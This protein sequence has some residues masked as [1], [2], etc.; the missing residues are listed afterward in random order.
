MNFTRLILCFAAVL[1]TTSILC[2]ETVHIVVGKNAP[3]LENFAAEEL[4]GQLPQV[5]EDVTAAVVGKIPDGATHVVLI[6]SPTTSDHVKAAARQKWPKLSDQ[7]IVVK[8]LSGDRQT[9]LVGGGSPVATLWA[10]Y[11]LGHRL[12]IRYLLRGDIFPIEKRPL[13][14]TGH[15]LVTEP[16]LRSRTWRT[17]NDF[18]IGPES[19]GLADH[20]KALKQL[21][22]LKY[23]RLMLQ[24]YPWQPFVSYEFDGVKKKTATLW[25]G[26]KF[27]VDGDTVGKKVFRGAK[28]FENPDLAGL[29]TSEELT[30]AGVGHVRGLIDAAHELGMTVGISISP[31][32]FPREFQQALPGSRVAHGLK[33]L[34]IIPAADQGPTDETL[35]KIVATKI[36]AYLETYP[37]LDT[38][39]LTMPEFPE[40]D[41][42]ADQAWKLLRPRLGDS[43]IQLAD[44]VKQA[45]KRGL[46][47]SGQRG[48]Q[49]LKGNLVGLA[50][51]Q[52]LF[53]DKDLLKR[54]GGSDTELF[55]TSVDPALYPVLDKVVPN[56]AATLNFVDYTARRIVENRAVLNQVPAGKVRSSLI[57][58][59]AD[60]NV[61]LLPQS[62]MHSLGELASDLKKH[63][64]DG[65]STRY[66]VPAE[67]DP[68][69]Y[70]LSRTSW[71][72]EL[73]A[74][75]CLKEFWTT[76]TGKEAA[77][78]RLVLAWQHLEKA[79]NRTDEMNIGFAFPVPGLLMKHYRPEPIPEWWQDITD[80]YTQY[81]IELY[82]AHGAFDRGSKH[83]LFYYAKRG[84]YV[85]EYL[86]AVKAV[87][88]AA[89]AKKAGDT[90]KALEHLETALESTYNCINTLSDVARDQS[91]RG[92]VAVLNAY[93]YRPLL[94]EYERLADEE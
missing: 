48:V 58:T 45:S 29:K 66:W 88:E 2:A 79:T 11:E 71:E 24:V 82:R 86:G 27:P 19:W 50:F 30:R 42:H 89:L 52:E 83:V 75:Q 84:E 7:G 31:L 26:E 74:E 63:G 51:F 59:L 94:A 14:L 81:M 77:A 23:N 12:G 56:G 91:D 35:R 20:K 87:R 78:D 8:S 57:L 32:E 90:E 64:W 34:T 65:F 61:G 92:L 70:F 37:K 41:Q 10:A 33:K 5:F 22:K 38:L 73:T 3:R 55:I 76:T 39:Y 68:A 46:I 17:I 4:A 18:P 13:D 72:K 49:S 9:V 1:S 85:L 43:Q 6:G 28:Y 60:D 25:Y 44:L 36:R 67:L 54:K 47:A 80:A 16:Q 53:K 21:A 62:A 69:I 40:W 15:D 93:A